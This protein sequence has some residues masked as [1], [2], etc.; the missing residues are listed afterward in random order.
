MRGAS[1][2]SIATM[3]LI[4]CGLMLSSLALIASTHSVR[5]DYA[6]L[7]M[8][9]L[10]RWQLQEDYTRLLLEMNTWAAPHRIEQLAGEQLSMRPPDLS[11]SK[12]VSP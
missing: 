6:R 2:R 10:E 12:V 4:V 3:V 5:E 8:L 9:E 11:L 7:Q 1:V